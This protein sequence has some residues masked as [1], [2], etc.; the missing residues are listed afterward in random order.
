[1]FEKYVDK[2][3]RMFYTYHYPIKLKINM[4]DPSSN[5][6]G[7]PS[8]RSYIHTRRMRL[9]LLK[10]N[11]CTISSVSLCFPLVNIGSLDA[12]LENHVIV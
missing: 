2:T 12:L 11:L 3:E 4:K 10:H 1:M 9:N 5:G 6:A 7:T 8:D